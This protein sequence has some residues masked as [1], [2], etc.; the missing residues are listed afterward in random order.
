M[1]KM[2]ILIFVLLIILSLTGCSLTKF[3]GSRT[4]NDSQLIMD[5][6]VLNTTDYQLLKLE[7]EDIVNVEIV[8][9]SGQLNIVVQKED[10]EPI[11][12]GE[13]IPTSSFQIV[14]PESGTY[15][16]LVTGKKAKGSISF[17][18]QISE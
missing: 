8:C 3:D 6:K 2:F 14:I 16:F 13:S 15:K 18:K 9:D 1:K 7:Q 5:F 17:I 4:G 10:D 11:Y 12:N